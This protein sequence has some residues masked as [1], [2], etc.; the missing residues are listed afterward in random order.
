MSLE[1]QSIERKSLKV[2]IGKT[3]DWAELA[4][5]CVCFANAQGGRLLIG[6]ED[7]QSTPPEG[8]RISDQNLEK[9]RTRIGELT[10][11]VAIAVQ[12]CLS[13]TTDGDYIEITVSRSVSP[14]STT[15]GRFYIRVGDSCKPLVGEDIQRLLNERSAQPWE[16]LTTL[17]VKR[18]RFDVDLLASFVSGIR[19]SSRVKTSVKEKTDDELIDHYYLAIGGYLTNLGTLCIGLREDRARLGTAPVIQCIK[20]DADGRKVNKIVW[21]DHTCSPAQLIDEVWLGVP[22]FRET[23]EL[24]DGLSRQHIPVYDGRIIRE[25]LVNALVHRPYTQRGDLYLNLYADRFEIVNPGL[26]PLGVTPQNIL[27]QSVRRNNE[28][29]RVFHDLGF[30]EREGSG[31]D[32]LYE[33]LL[34]Q[35]RQLPQLREGL[36][37]VTVV[38]EKR[39][40]KPAIIDFLTKADQ[41]FS[42]RQRE[43]IALGLL[44]QHESLSAR[45]LADILELSTTDEV[46]SWTGRLLDLKLVQQMGRTKGTRYY[47]DPELYRKL[48]FHH[49]TSLIRIESHRLDALVLEDVGRYPGSAIGEIHKRIGPEINRRQIKLALDRLCK[50]DELRPEG[51]KRGRRYWPTERDLST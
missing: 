37:S 24:P 20:Y 48:N 28:L 41:V 23:Y 42:L 19:A 7:G 27:H 33:V 5:D 29:A 46:I 14:A 15:D 1:G 6:I 4:K 47:V 45:D 16:T 18:S 2:I 51:Q 43:K 32:L 22:D 38:I 26:L 39:I 50:K 21:D 17:A 9:V 3:A 31:Y 30:M 12:L 40:V 13:D 11:N 10:V 25:L 49:Q 44:A 34:S 36:D 8:Q 35:G